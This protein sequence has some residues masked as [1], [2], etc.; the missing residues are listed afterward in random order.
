[1]PLFLLGSVAGKPF[2]P[3]SRVFPPSS[4]L[5]LGRG[6]RPLPYDGRQMLSS[7]VGYIFPGS[8]QIHF[9]SPSRH[10]IFVITPFFNAP[11]IT[12]TPTKLWWEMWFEKILIQGRVIKHLECAGHC[13]APG[14]CQWMRPSVLLNI[15]VWRDRHPMSHY[16]CEECYRRHYKVV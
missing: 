8:F 6:S 7:S 4:S 11:Y 12:N 15:T 13:G 2:L 3:L 10:F 16:N 9:G 1:M 14:L 5:F